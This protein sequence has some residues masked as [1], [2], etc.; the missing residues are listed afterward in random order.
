M[1]I[2]RSVRNRP[3]WKWRFI[4]LTI[5]LAWFTMAEVHQICLGDCLT[6]GLHG[7]D[8]KAMPHGD[9]RSISRG[10]SVGLANFRWLIFR[11]IFRSCNRFLDYAKHARIWQVSP[12]RCCNNICQ[13]ST[14]YSIGNQCFDNFANYIKNNTGYCFVID[15]SYGLSLPQYFHM[16]I[17]YSCDEL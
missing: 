17:S 12:Q 11:E 14:W 16:M 4:L 10:T 6:A 2:L 15:R 5:L 9:H 7:C 1:Y 13:I 8:S 3:E